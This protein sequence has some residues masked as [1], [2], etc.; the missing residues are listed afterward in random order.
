[1]HIQICIREIVYNKKNNISTDRVKGMD[2]KKNNMSTD[3]ENGR[4]KRTSRG[5]KGKRDGLQE[6]QR[7]HGQGKRET[8]KQHNGNQ[9]KLYLSYACTCTSIYISHIIIIGRAVVAVA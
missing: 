6:E 7:E 9:N 8:G 4:G 3:R 1:M 5:K 2:C